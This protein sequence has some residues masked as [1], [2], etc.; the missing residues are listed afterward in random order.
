MKYFIKVFIAGIFSSY[1]FNV[2]VAQNQGKIIEQQGG[3]ISV[4]SK[5]TFGTRVSISLPCA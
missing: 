5:E 3:T 4:T 1:F 2:S